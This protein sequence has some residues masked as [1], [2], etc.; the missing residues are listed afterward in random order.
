MKSLRTTLE[1][2]EKL[3]YQ[4]KPKAQMSRKKM[5]VENYVN[6]NTNASN[7]ITYIDSNTSISKLIGRKVEKEKIIVCDGHVLL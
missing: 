6:A 7:T 1:L 5:L 4:Q 2:T 3:S